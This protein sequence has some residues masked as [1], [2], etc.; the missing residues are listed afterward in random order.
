MLEGIKLLEGAIPII[1]HHHERWDGT[2]FPGKLKG[3]DIP[4]AARILYLVEKVEE[5]RMIGLRGDDLYEKA[6]K[7]AKEGA[8]TRFDPKVVEVFVELL[9]SQEGV[10]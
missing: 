4:L 8:G 5:L 6:I 10:W 9:G 3:E 1:Q 7:E 2:G